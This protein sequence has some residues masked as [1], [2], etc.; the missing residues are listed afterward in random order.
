MTSKEALRLI[1]DR[2]RKERD[3][4]LKFLAVEMENLE[5]HVR[6]TAWAFGKFSRKLTQVEK[7]YELAKTEFEE[8]KGLV[9]KYITEQVNPQ[10]GRTY[11]VEFAQLVY[12]QHS[13][14]KHLKRIVLDLKYQMLDLKRYLKALETKVTLMPGSQGLRNKEVDAQELT[15]L[16]T[17][18]E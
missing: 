5:D 18:D 13:K 15:E 3:P 9:I 12:N 4:T 10:T 7:Q 6:Y 1:E 11:S 14:A 16:E 8:F 17:T 2:F